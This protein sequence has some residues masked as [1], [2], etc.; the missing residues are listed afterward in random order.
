MAF[1][2]ILPGLV[3]R[4]QC[5]NNNRYT[6]TYVVKTNTVLYV[7]AVETFNCVLGELPERLLGF[8]N[9][10]CDFLLFCVQSPT[11]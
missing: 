8:L 3:W 9:R 7:V 2:V 1:W 5:V 6:R 4:F 10:T 11:D